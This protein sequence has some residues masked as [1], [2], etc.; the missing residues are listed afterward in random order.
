MSRVTGL[1]TFKMKV[2][3]E[4][5][6]AAVEIKE[7]GIPSEKVVQIV[8]GEWARLAVPGV[9]QNRI[10]CLGWERVESP[11]PESQ[12]VKAIGPEPIFFWRTI[13]R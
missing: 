5:R 8:R 9:S 2:K 4:E 6:P 13:H 12:P 7:P 10:E 11:P 1:F 3:G